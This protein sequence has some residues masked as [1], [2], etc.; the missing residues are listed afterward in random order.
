[1]LDSHQVVGAPGENNDNPS[2]RERYPQSSPCSSPNP[3]SDSSGFPSSLRN[4]EKSSLSPMTSATS[5]STSAASDALQ[6]PTLASHEKH[7][8]KRDELLSFQSALSLYHA[9]AAISDESNS[10][11]R[12]GDGHDDNN[13]EAE[14]QREAKRWATHDDAID[15]HIGDIDTDQRN[16]S[17]AGDRARCQDPRGGTKLEEQRISV[18]GG[19]VTRQGPKENGDD[20]E[21]TTSWATSSSSSTTETPT[22]PNFIIRH[23]KKVG[24]IFLSLV[25]LW[26][27]AQY[28]KW[29]ERQRHNHLRHGRYNNNAIQRLGRLFGICRWLLQLIS[30]SQ[31]S[32]YLRQRLADVRLKYL[33][34]SPTATS[35]LQPWD[36]A[37]AT[38]LSHLLSMTKAGTISKVMLRGSVL[39]YLHTMKSKSTPMHERHR[40]SQTYLQNPKVLNEIISTL[41]NHGC[42]DITTL[43]ESLWKR[44]LNGPAVMAFPFAYLAALYWMMR[45]LQRQQFQDDNGEGDSWQKGVGGTHGAIEPST[46]FEDVAGIDSSLQELSEVI[47]YMR[48]PASFHSVGAQPPRG[49]LLYGPPGSGKTLLARA[50]AGEAKRSV[51][52]AHRVGGNTIDCFAVCSGSEFV[53]TYV[54]RGAARVRSLFRNVREQAMGNFKR[55]TKRQMKRWHTVTNDSRTEGGIVMRMQSLLS[56]FSRSDSTVEEDGQHK[57]MAIV[58]I[59]EIDA[60]AKRRDTGVGLPSSLGGGGCDEREQTLNQLLTEMDGFSTGSASS[61]VDVIVIGATNRPEVLDPAIMRPGRF[62]RHVR[63]SLPNAHGREAILR[64]HARRIRWDRTSVNFGELSTDN[65][66]GAMLKNVINEAALLAVRNGCSM[67]TQN[68]LLGAVQKV[69]AAN[70][71]VVLPSRRDFVH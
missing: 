24:G 39:S 66:S 28:K 49:I 31:I 1:M 59:D 21:S 10:F 50:I 44:F 25:S 52:G 63:L 64:V 40:W 61:R 16:T 48:N 35:S 51:D 34:K 15:N 26:A 58:F 37:T 57:P 20:D 47:A 42:D 7:A 32:K 27:Y 12:R 17:A 3:S 67:V 71:F 55:R 18:D 70:R 4:V 23:R 8:S 36:D 11:G 38:P 14:S 62:D 43:P 60:L 46:T 22:P 33:Q 5:T 29:E 53:E 45:R 65:F 68:H 69:R 2:R 56:P 30:P 9:F 54:G 19:S 6:S 13:R 41:I